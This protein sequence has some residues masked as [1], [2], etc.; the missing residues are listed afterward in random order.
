MFSD[1]RDEMGKKK[2]QIEEVVGLIES[3]SGLTPHKV[4]E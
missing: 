1:A 3:S 4:L 2:Q